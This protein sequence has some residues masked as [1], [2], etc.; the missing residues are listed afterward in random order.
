MQDPV[1][2]N[3]WLVQLHILTDLVEKAY[4]PSHVEARE[5]ATRTPIKQA[6][7]RLLGC[8]P[9]ASP[10]MWKYPTPFIP[11]LTSQQKKHFVEQLPEGQRHLIEMKIPH[12]QKRLLELLPAGFW[13]EPEGRNNTRHFPHQGRRDT[14][15]LIEWKIQ[16]LNL[17]CLS[18]MSP[19]TRTVTAATF[20]MKDTLFS[21]NR[22]YVHHVVSQEE[23]DP[24]SRKPGFLPL[25]QLCDALQGIL[26][27]NG[28]SQVQAWL[29]ERKVE[30]AEQVEQLQYVKEILEVVALDGSVTLSL[31]REK[32]QGMSVAELYDCVM[33]NIQTQPTK[34]A[35]VTTAGE[36]L[37]L[38]STTLVTSALGLR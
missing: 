12:E 34:L 18:H 11:P 24:L 29:D 5:M 23:G 25:A 38:N 1:D 27:S 15:E 4:R 36:K 32:L 37:D 19:S 17:K 7:R 22:S 28:Q 16:Q 3:Q 6:M 30:Q 13:Q 31:S 35:L 21:N 14:K 10:P 2:A 9:D 33:K 26:N 8:L 20:V